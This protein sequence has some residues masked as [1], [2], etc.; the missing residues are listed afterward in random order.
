MLTLE[1]PAVTSAILFV[2]FTIKFCRGSP[3]G[4]L[5]SCSVIACTKVTKLYS[6][7]VVT[8]AMFSIYSTSISSS[9]RGILVLFIGLRVA[10]TG[11]GFLLALM[12]FSL[13]KF[14]W[15]Q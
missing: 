1:K 10:V 8:S 11:L 2:S 15:V 4:A 9:T 3:A 6:A 12:T 13:E 7:S 14:L 5:L